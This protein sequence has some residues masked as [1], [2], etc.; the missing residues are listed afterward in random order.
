M[1]QT[2]KFVIIKNKTA[3]KTE[4]KNINLPFAFF[5]KNPMITV[6]END[7]YTAHIKE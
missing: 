4:F 3:D 6:A 5:I 7:K 2:A 1:A